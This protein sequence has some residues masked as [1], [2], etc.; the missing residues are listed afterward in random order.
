MPGSGATMHTTNIGALEDADY[1]TY[2]YVMNVDT[3][4]VI[5]TVSIKFV[6]DRRNRIANQPRQS[7]RYG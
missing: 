3:T 4:H 6:F 7:L 2:G 5:T 1:C